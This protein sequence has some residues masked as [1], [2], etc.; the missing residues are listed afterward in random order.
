MVET[1]FQVVPDST[2]AASFGLPSKLDLSLR[3]RGASGLFLFRGGTEG[4]T[5]VYELQLAADG[6]SGHF[7]TG[8]GTPETSEPLVKV[9]TMPVMVRAMLDESGQPVVGLEPH[10]SL[11]AGDPT[12]G[13]LAPMAGILARLIP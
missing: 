9:T 1:F 5:T 8:L 7:L 12:L 11:R 3:G 4:E 2:V 6:Q 13:F 10:P